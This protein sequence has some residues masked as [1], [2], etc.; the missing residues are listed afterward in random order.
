MALDLREL[1]VRSAPAP[2]RP[3]D[4]A[5]VLQRGRLLARRR[6]I[7]VASLTGLMSI[8]L[9]AVV[10]NL[11]QRVPASGTHRNPTAGGGTRSL[12]SLPG[13]ILFSAFEDRDSTDSALFVMK[14]SGTDR[15]R[16]CFDGPTGLGHQLE[17]PA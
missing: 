10:S 9:V 14:P 2:S 1:I 5:A 15:T 13:T 7:M 17:H 6:T 3:L 8:G 16:I 11:G 4:T 12:S